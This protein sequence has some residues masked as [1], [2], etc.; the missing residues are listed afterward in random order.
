MSELLK[1]LA[2]EAKNL[3]PRKDSGYELI[4][5]Y[6]DF[7]IKKEMKRANKYLSVLPSVG[8]CVIQTETP[9]GIN[10]KTSPATKNDYI[11]FTSSMPSLE[12]PDYF[13]LDEVP[14]GS[15]G[16]EFI[17]GLFGRE[18]MLNAFAN[19]CLPIY[20]RRKPQDYAH[21]RNVFIK[22]E[23]VYS[24][25]KELLLALKDDRDAYEAVCKNPEFVYSVCHLFGMENGM[26]FIKELVQSLV[27]RKGTSNR[28]IS[29]R[30]Y[31][32]NHDW[33]MSEGVCEYCQRANI[34]LLPMDYGTFRD[35]V[36]YESIPLG[37]ANSLNSFF[38]AWMS[39]LDTQYEVFGEIREIF[40]KDFCLLKSRLEGI[41]CLIRK[42]PTLHHS[43]DQTAYNGSDGDY[44]FSVPSEKKALCIDLVEQKNGIMDYLIPF[45]KGECTLL[46]MR[47]VCGQKEPYIT[48]AVKDG[49]IL[50]A[51]RSITGISQKKNTKP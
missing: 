45:A 51:K 28:C 5:D 23:S 18:T 19:G 8:R 15:K 30:A 16:A 50:L 12:L 46:F 39:T 33:E 37:A 48:A 4:L 22:F 43:K 35:F 2:E 29:N 49:N 10:I 3:N 7:I 1:E 27:Y 44:V 31:W 25:N 6:P 24:H 34:P 20:T 21:L 41:L 42:C 38:N 14:R 9:N 47:P 32:H 40:P 11:N 36:L 17:F 26:S 13:W